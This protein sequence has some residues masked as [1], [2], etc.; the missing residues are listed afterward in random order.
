MATKSTYLTFIRY[1]INEQQCIPV[2]KDWNALFLFMKEQALL[3]VGF[4]G[5][6]RMKAAGIDIP[7][8]VFLRWYALSEKIRVCNALINRR[9]TELVKMLDADGFRS[10]I[11]K[12][13]G[14]ALMYPEPYMR[15]PGDID[16]FV[17]RTERAS[18]GERRREV[19]D[20]VRERFPETDIRYQHIDCLVFRDV[21]VEVHFI[22]TVMNNPMYN[23]RIQRWTETQMP[24]QCGNMVRLPDN[25]GVIA[26]PTADFNVIYQL[27]H[28]MHH[29][30]D[31]GL[32]LRQVMDYYYVLKMWSRAAGEKVRM[33]LVGEL[34]YL[35][36]YKFAGA[37]M[38]VLREVFDMEEGLM[39]VPVDEWRGKTL[40]AEIL[41]GGNF[42][43]YSGLTG[44]SMGVKY[45]LKIRRNLRFVLEY[46][47]EALCEPV[48]R[49]W[50]FFWRIAN[51]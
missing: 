25:V 4:R 33:S 43:K 48:F 34:K 21:L 10:C 8:P 36:L 3:G 12:G 47:A 7:K 22:P 38:Y 28:M 41:K 14:N 32:G 35:G 30:F 51:R 5:V 6:E 17:M 16:V 40:M 1:C 23:Q 31:E 45:F 50:H 2:I 24:K 18:V 26:M 29:F 20:Y 19:M 42:G 15:N 44:Y 13:Q 27:S 37:V 49:T 9:C 46:P 39:I 11:L